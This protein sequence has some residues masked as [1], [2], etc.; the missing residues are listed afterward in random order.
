MSAVGLPPDAAATATA[1][2]A[3]AVNGM[4]ARRFRGFLPVVIDVETGGFHSSTDALLEIAAVL[5]EMDPD[6]TLKRGVTHSYHVK[7]FEGARLDP[8]AL[9]ITGIDPFHPLRPA[10]PERDALGRVFRA[11]RRAV[12]GYN[13][14]RAILVGHN[15]AFDLGFLNAAIVRAE[16]KRNPFHPFSCF[17]TATLAG[18]ALGQT[19][20]AKA[21]AVAGLEWD[22]SSAHSAV[23]DA[24]RTAEIFCLICN[25]M[26]DSYRDAQE[27]ARA[28]GWQNAPPVEA[29]VDDPGLA[30][31]DEATDV[32][33]KP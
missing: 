22:Q 13:C 30:L 15:A 6:G 19:V 17:D 4:M 20:L 26:N 11:I 24:E 16:V 8:A 5:I 9:T 12:H 10:L 29:M 7:P 2:G 23:Y 18:A 3:A 33:P 21:L 14:R 31:E 28:M 27:R 32:P 25:R 1:P